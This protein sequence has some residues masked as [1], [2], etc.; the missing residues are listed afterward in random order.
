MIKALVVDDERIAR[1]ELRRLLQAHPTVQ[2]VGEAMD[3]EEADA[4]LA[5][6]RADVVFLDM[7]MPGESGMVLARRLPD[8]LRV[9]FCTAHSAFAT[10][11]FEINAV[12]Y[13]LKPIS[14]E[15]LARAVARLGGSNL[16]QRTDYLPI[17]FAIILKFNDVGRVVR[18]R[19]IERFESV[20]NYV[21]VHCRHG[22]ALI[23][24]TIV[25]LEQRLDPDHFL[26][27]NR[28]EIVRIDAIVNIG[29]GENGRQ[30][31]TLESGKTIEISRRQAQLMRTRMA[32]L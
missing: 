25:R 27:V 32:M 10:E 20:G 29:N 11:A 26:R 18:L 1:A 24:G 8:H 23:V 4:L 6:M 19:E 21:G 2:I 13:L 28:A 3:V 9:V 31:A 15:G 14:P 16:H 17:D 12:D 7:D 22:A 30:D 5:S